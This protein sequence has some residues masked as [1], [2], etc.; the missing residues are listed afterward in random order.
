MSGVDRRCYVCDQTEDLRDVE[1][2]NPG[3]PGD[4][5][6]TLACPRCEPA[7]THCDG[8]FLNAAEIR[9]RVQARLNARPAAAADAT[10]ERSG[11]AP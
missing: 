9:A 7:I 4:T 10:P 6:G 8:L 3:L 11:G 5:I 2:E 1:I